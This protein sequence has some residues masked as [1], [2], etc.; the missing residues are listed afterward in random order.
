MKLAVLF[1]SKIL[2]RVGR[3]PLLARCGRGSARVIPIRLCSCHRGWDPL[4]HIKWVLQ[5]VHPHASMQAVLEPELDAVAKLVALKTPAELEEIRADRLKFWTQR[6]MHLQTERLSWL[7]GAPEMLKPLLA[8]IHGPLL[9]E[10]ALACG[11]ERGLANALQ[12]GL[13]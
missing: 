12:K 2:S 10:L 13:P 11:H 5:R 3:G 6:A 8:G 9:S 7:Q 4:Q 1:L